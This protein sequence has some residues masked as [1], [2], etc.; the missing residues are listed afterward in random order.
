MSRS[1]IHP[2]DRQPP[3]TGAAAISTP[4]KTE[5]TMFDSSTSAPISTAKPTRRGFRIRAA[6]IITGVA[7]ALGL[8]GASA[9]TANVNIA[10]VTFSSDVTCSSSVRGL[11]VFARSS[12][13]QPGSSAMIY[14]YNYA[15]KRWVHENQWHTVSDWAPIHDSFNFV[16][17]GYY[18]VYMRYAQHTT[19]GWMYRGEYINLIYQSNANGYGNHP[20]RYCY[21]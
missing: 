15:A 8:F 12:F 6:G 20:S 14:L 17:H 2:L 19:S 16:G 3:H 1:S 10:G 7:L 13:D 5:Q 9:A 18:K 4:P 21:I 11:E